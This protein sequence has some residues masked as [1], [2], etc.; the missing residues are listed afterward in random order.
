MRRFVRLYNDLDASNRTGD[1][2]AAL[3]GYF[4]DTPAED[5]AWALFFLTGQRLPRAVNSTLLRAW[6][7]AEAGL[8]GWMVE[9]CYEAIGDLAETA[10]MLIPEPEPPEGDGPAAPFDEPLHRVIEDRLAPLRDM[11]ERDRRDALVAM[12]RRL[13]GPARFVW[14]KLITGGFRVGVART[15]VERALADVAGV[16]APVMAHRLMGTWRPAAADY[17]R[18]LTG[19]GLGD[20][21]GRPYPFCLA[22]PLEAHPATLGDPAMWQAEWK[23]DGIRAQLVKRAGQALLWS[24]GEELL[25]ERFPEIVAAAAGFPDGTVIDGEVMA[26]RG[27]GPLPFADLQRRITKKSVGAKLMAEVPVALVAYDLIETE[28]IDLRTRPLSERRARLEAL[29][30]SV[31]DCR[32][33]EASIE[34]DSAPTGTGKI[35]QAE[36]D[37]GFGFER[38]PPAT[39]LPKIVR[40]PGVQVSESPGSATA[41]RIRLSPIHGT[42]DWKSLAALRAGSRAALAEGLMLKR[43]ASPYGTGRARGDWWKWKIEP[44]TVDAV[45]VA[46]QKGH[47]RR[48]ELFSDYSFALWDGPELTTVAKAYSGLTDAELKEIDGFIRKNT[49]GKFGSVRS[50]KPVLVF[51]LAFEGIQPSPRHKSGVATRFPRILNWRRDKAA[52]EADTLDALLAMAELNRAMPG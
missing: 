6:I 1:K 40:R 10:A 33:P 4:R 26:W 45:L 22:H 23:W 43:L 25:T 7:G 44:Y 21:P 18:I 20:E 8:P 32:P 16:E 36:L 35:G 11:P 42:S 24:R 51:E 41:T 28:G 46:A 38:T 30:A 9:E 2:V 31:D 37:F 50:V 49:T 15:L 17:H 47:G 27:D 19:E 39:A 29:L 34:I 48:A 3:V 13:D 14:N 12:W 5:A 52:E